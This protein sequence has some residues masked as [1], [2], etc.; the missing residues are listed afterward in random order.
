MLDAEQ[1]S[2]VASSAT[3]ARSQPGS[4]LGHLE[5]IELRAGAATLADG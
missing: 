3:L 4:R 5:V 1:P 2:A